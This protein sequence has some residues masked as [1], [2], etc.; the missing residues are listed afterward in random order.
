MEMQINAE[1]C[2]GCGACVEICP[3]GAMQLI[4]GLAVLDQAACTQCQSCVDACPVGAIV[5]VELP[6]AVPKPVAIQPVGEAGITVT[7]PSQLNPKPWVGAVL[8]FAGQEILPRL[9]YALL[10]ALDRRL[11]QTQLA[12]PQASLPSQKAE[13]VSRQKDGQ[14]YRRRR[15]YGLK[16][17]RGGGRGRGAGRKNWI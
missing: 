10:A 2:T 11:A 13:T 15:R 17:Q 4:D 5:A 6:I 3:N 1:L 7:E 8:A 12:Q 16:R 9:A 14:E